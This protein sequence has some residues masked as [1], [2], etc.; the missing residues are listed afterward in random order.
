[1]SDDIEPLPLDSQSE[2][3]HPWNF[4]IAAVVVTVVGSAIGFIILFVL[5]NGGIWS[6]S[7]TGNSIFATVPNGQYPI[8][9]TDINSPSSMAP[10]GVNALSG[11]K[12]AYVSSFSGSE[13]PTGW[14][15]FTGV[16]GGNP[17]GQFGASHVVVSD[18]LLHL[19]T[20]RD[21]MYG[22]K[23]VTG[24]LCQCGLA[25][26]YGAYFVRSRNT[27]AGANEAEV[28][29]PKSNI[30]P[31]EIDFNETG[32]SAISTSSTVHFGAQNN[33]VQLHL[34]IDMTKWHT[35]GVVWTANSI[36]YVVDG[37]QWGQIAVAYEIPNVPMTL[38]FEQR[39]S[40]KPVRDCP[41]GPVS[42]LVDWV[43]EYAPT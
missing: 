23:W 4:Q 30:W 32:S 11:Y 43:A 9:V 35:W 38:D 40:C 26:T 16:P 34:N 36:T 14:F 19:N 22:N 41:S 1:M 8:G 18:G 21:P 3:R 39:T 15:V 7:G 2:H 28:L 24:G 5:S 10:P 20:W 42:M 13:L 17:D 33:I 6:L 27:G 29:W 12:R 31:P 37:K 25:R